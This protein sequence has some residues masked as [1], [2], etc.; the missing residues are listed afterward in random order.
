MGESMS[1]FHRHHWEVVD[2]GHFET[3]RFTN[4]GIPLRLDDTHQPGMT[5]TVALYHC[6]D[7]GDNKTEELMGGWTLDQLKEA[8]A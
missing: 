6:A 4:E 7:C 3:V 2:V 1:W 8:K 5:T